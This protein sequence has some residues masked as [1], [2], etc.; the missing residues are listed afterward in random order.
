MIP[1]LLMQI[2][3]K[4]LTRFFYCLIL[5]EL[6]PRLELFL[7][8]LPLVKT[9]KI[10]KNFLLSS[11]PSIHLPQPKPVSKHLSTWLPPRRTVLFEE[12]KNVFVELHGLKKNRTDLDSNS[13]ILP[14]LGSWTSY[15]NI[16]I[17]FL[18]FKTDVIISAQ[19]CRK[20]NMYSS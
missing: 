17:S 9:R 6:K 4:R 13:P 8:S 1:L 15:W 7:N 3:E 11:T 18:I 14:T 20:E 2:K 5:E 10:Q 16:R 12:P 19:I